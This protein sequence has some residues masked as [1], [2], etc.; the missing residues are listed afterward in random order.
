MTSTDDI[1]LVDFGAPYPGEPANRRPAVIVG[2]DGLFA[3]AIPQV[4]VVP[5]TTRRRG[6][7]IHVEIEA[8]AASGLDVDSYAQCELV[9]A[10]SSRRLVHRLGRAAPSEGSA[11][12]VVLGRLLG[13]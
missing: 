13:I 12:H 11:V 8:S 2:P 5:L 3:D 4:M 1:W 10:V 7:S 9:R 6:L